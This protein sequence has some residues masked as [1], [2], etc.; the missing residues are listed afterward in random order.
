[1]GIIYFA[2]LSMLI[3]LFW[4]YITCKCSYLYIQHIRRRLMHHILLKGCAGMQRGDLP[5]LSAVTVMTL[6]VAGQQGEAEFRAEVRS[7]GT[8]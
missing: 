1:M 2:I 4:D 5:D 3:Y 6:K 8:T 7:I